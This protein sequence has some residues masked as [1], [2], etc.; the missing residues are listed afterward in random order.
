MV[1]PVI[2]VTTPVKLVTSKEVL[3]IVTLVPPHTT[4]SKDSVNTHVQKVTMVMM[5]PEPVNNVC[6][7]VLPVPD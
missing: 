7:N 4:Y 2:L 6:L 3:M 1:T 5:N